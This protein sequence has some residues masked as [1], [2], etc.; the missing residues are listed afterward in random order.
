MTLM[1]ILIFGLLLLIVV[2]LFEIRSLYK[3][4]KA[5]NTRL[6]ER[7]DY[8][9]N[10]NFGCPW[11]GQH[12]DWRIIIRDVKRREIPLNFG[13]CQKHIKEGVEEILREMEGR[14]K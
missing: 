14:M 3:D 1:L 12:A 13:V 10:N 4:F 6:R 7:L 8:Y 9:E 5:E 2:S 11:C